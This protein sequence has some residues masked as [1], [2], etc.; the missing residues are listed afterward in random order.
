[1]VIINHL[2]VKLYFKATEPHTMLVYMITNTLFIL[3]LFLNWEIEKK[4]HYLSDGIIT[5][6]VGY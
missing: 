5:D 2:G 3:F 6:G 4:R 1:M